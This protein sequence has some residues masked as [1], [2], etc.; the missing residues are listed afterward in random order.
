M[1]TAKLTFQTGIKAS[2]YA[3]VRTR[4]EGGLMHVYFDPIRNTYCVG[5]ETH[6]VEEPFLLVERWY[7]GK[8]DYPS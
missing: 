2:Q 6:A 3:E 8:L 4:E 5:Y 1:S 7:K